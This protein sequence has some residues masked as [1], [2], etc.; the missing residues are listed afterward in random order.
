[1][2][3]WRQPTTLASLSA[4]LSMAINF[5]C[6]CGLHTRRGRGQDEPDGHS[7]RPVVKACWWCGDGGGAHVDPGPGRLN[8]RQS[9]AHQSPANSNK[10]H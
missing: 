8:G 6:M 4:H 2:L 10:N 7:A 1:M 5:G 9:M 3:L